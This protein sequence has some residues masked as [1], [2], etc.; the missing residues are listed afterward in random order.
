MSHRADAMLDGG[1]CLRPELDQQ[2][3]VKLCQFDD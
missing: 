1:F 3:V 2:G